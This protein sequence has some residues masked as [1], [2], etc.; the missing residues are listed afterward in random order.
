MIKENKN[1][2]IRFMNLID[3]FYEYKVNVICLAEGNQNQIYEHLSKFPQFKRTTSRLIEMK[4][5]FYLSLPYN[6]I[7]KTTR[8]I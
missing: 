5:E 8:Q 6:K 3:V 7:N 1:E 2:A 4:S